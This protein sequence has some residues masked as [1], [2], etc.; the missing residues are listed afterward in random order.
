MPGW[1]TKATDIAKEAALEHCIAGACVHVC[2]QMTWVF[3][4]NQSR[5]IK[6]LISF[7][8]FLFPKLNSFKVYFLTITCLRQKNV[9]VLNV[10]MPR[11]SPS[12]FFFFFFTYSKQTNYSLGK[13]AACIGAEHAVHCKHFCGRAKTKSTV[14]QSLQPSQLANVLALCCQWK[15][16]TANPSHWQQL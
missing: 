9:R 2:C 3:T 1:N 15:N 6:S 11:L 14:E 13:Q 10:I 8:S 16:A 5:C 12:A 4:H 7:F